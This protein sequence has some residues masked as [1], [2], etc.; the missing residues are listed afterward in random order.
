[1]GGRIIAAIYI[2]AFLFAAIMWL[3]ETIVSIFSEI[4]CSVKKC[5]KTKR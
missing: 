5:R 4:Y 2:F 1:M 3:I